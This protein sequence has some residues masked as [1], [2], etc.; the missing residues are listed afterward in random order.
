MAGVTSTHNS[1][2]PER[3]RFGIRQAR[4]SSWG[5]FFA[6][7]ILALYLSQSQSFL[8]PLGWLALLFLVM[9]LRNRW[10]LKMENSL[11]D[12]PFGRALS[13]FRLTSLA[14][15][16]V[17]ALLPALVL[18]QLPLDQ[19]FFLTTVLCIWLAGGMMSIGVIPR[20]FMGYAGLIVTGLSIGWLRSPHEVSIT[21]I[22]LLLLYTLVLIAFFRNFSQVIED[23]CRIRLVNQD[24]VKELTLANDTKTRFILAASHDLKQPLQALVLFSHALTHSRDPQEMQTIASGIQQSVKALGQ[25]FSAVL[26]LGKID[27]KVITPL[28]QTVFMP[29]LM[30]RLSR[31][32]DFLCQ[33]K[34]LVWHMQHLP[35]TIRT[36]PI[37]LERLLRNLLDNAVHHGAQGPVEVRMSLEKDLKITVSDRGPGIPPEE[38]EHVFKEFYRLTPARALGGLGLGLALV[39]RLVQLLGYELSVDYTD[40]QHRIGTQFTLVL[41]AASV[42]A[43]PG[44]PEPLTSSRGEPVVSTDTLAGLSVL[45]IDDDRDVLHATL[46]LLRQWGCRALGAMSMEAFLEISHEPDFQ[47]DV[48]LIDNNQ[49]A[50]GDALVMASAVL[51]QWPDTGVILI[52]GESDPVVLSRLRDGGY[53]LLEKPIAPDKLRQVLELFR[54]LD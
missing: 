35:L 6:A 7:P 9:A 42:L 22:S 26:D 29:D 25:L 53:P 28:E 46:M 3:L 16:F 23:G 51:D 11:P 36:D 2:E 14:L 24:L 52:T 47:P 27:A 49:L 18:P 19:G 30:G 13:A 44:M 41:P 21:L 31:E 1:V 20:L 12:M 39:Q 45:V 15:A 38:R 33:E 8:L 32:Y 37:L 5:G 54:H 43:E 34:G 17:I 48:A 4:K 40:P 50:Q 10:L